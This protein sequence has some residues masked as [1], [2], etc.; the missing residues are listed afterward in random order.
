MDDYKTQLEKWKKKYRGKLS[1]KAKAERLKMEADL[2]KR[3]DDPIRPLAHSVVDTDKAAYYRFL[4]TMR[5]SEPD[6]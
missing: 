5:D 4:R 6:K 3:F 1:D 2:K